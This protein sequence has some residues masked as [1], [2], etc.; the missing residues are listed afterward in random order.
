MSIDTWQAVAP[1]ALRNAKPLERLG[2][3]VGFLFTLLLAVSLALLAGAVVLGCGAIPGA[4]P[5][6]KGVEIADDVCEILVRV[7][8]PNTGKLVAVRVPAAALRKDATRA[9]AGGSIAGC[10]P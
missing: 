4:G 10:E 1:P 5:A 2:Y 7:P 9:L 6:C 3:T 8:D